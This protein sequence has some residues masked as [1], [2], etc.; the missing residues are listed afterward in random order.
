MGTGL[1]TRQRMSIKKKMEEEEM[2]NIKDARKTIK[3][4]I[5]YIYLK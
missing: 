4:N 5:F 1:C 2:N 3:H